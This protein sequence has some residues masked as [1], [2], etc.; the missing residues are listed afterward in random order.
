MVGTID[1][2]IPWQLNVLVVWDGETQALTLVGPTEENLVLHPL[3]ALRVQLI[4][5]A[6]LG[7]P[8]QIQTF[9]VRNL[10]RLAPDLFST[11]IK[12]DMFGFWI[13]TV[14]YQQLK[15]VDKLRQQHW[16]WSIKEKVTELY[17]FQRK[18]SVDKK[19]YWQFHV[20]W[21][22]EIWPFKIQ[23]HLKSRPF[24]RSDF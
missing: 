10:D 7:T 21:G 5:L 1:A 17:L 13:P 23:K 4:L 11:I 19:S 18:I 6:L 20:Q 12:L 8:F 9:G 14:F 16:T 3:A 15:K 22:S 24:W 2:I